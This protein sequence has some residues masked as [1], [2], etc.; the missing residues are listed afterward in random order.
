MTTNN[1]KIDAERLEV[2]GDQAYLF[3]GMLFN[4]IAVHYREDG[5]IES[6]VEFRDGI[7]NGVIRNWDVNGKLI[8]QGETKN[9]AFHGNCRTWDVDGRLIQEDKYEYGIRVSRKRWSENGDVIEDTMLERGNP[10]FELLQSAR[11][12][13]AFEN[14]TQ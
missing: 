8:F 7:Q 5:S 2:T 13:F 3:D 12:A 6:E 1:R 10:N 4:G 9:G 14:E 11:R